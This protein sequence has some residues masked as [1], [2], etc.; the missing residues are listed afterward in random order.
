[1]RTLSN[2]LRG[3]LRV[4][5]STD[6]D[7]EVMGERPEYPV[8]EKDDPMSP[9]NYPATAFLTGNPVVV[10][11]FGEDGLTVLLVEQKLPFA[12]RYADRFTIMDRGRGV[13]AGE[14]GALSDDLIQ[15][16]LTV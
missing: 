14:I 4:A 2:S 16:H 3:A 15:E 5:A 1:M 8:G 6:P 11:R 7:G 10:D 12:R 9:G 13:A